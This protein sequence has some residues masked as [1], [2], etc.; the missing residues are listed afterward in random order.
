MGPTSTIA[1]KFTSLLN[2]KERRRGSVQVLSTTAGASPRQSL[3]EKRVTKEEDTSAE[4][5]KEKVTDKDVNLGP[6]AKGD[7]L[8]E[9]SMER[10]NEEDKVGS[11]PLPPKD[12]PFTKEDDNDITPTATSEGV[13]VNNLHRRAHTVLEP[14]TQ[15]RPKHDRRGS[16]GSM[17]R[18][19]GTQWSRKDR[20]A[21]RPRTAGGTVTAAVPRTAGPETQTFNIDDDTELGVVRSRATVPASTISGGDARTSDG[22]DERPGE[23]SDSGKESG[24]DI[25]PVYLKGLFR[26]VC[27]VSFTEGLLA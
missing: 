6:P 23:T 10:I 21:A 26:F 2:P 22:D 3:D 13:A 15:G 12:V 1:R 25:K 24:A 4:G 8:R 17:G 18:M 7:A 16:S 19:L 5:E 20:D 27:Y 14:K 9:P 11:P